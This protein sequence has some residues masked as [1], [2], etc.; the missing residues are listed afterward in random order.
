MLFAPTSVPPASPVGGRR[1]RTV[2]SVPESA[3]SGDMNWRNLMARFDQLAG[4]ETG[5]VRSELDLLGIYLMVICP[6]VESSQL[7]A[8]L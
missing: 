5:P 1:A 4:T 2:A 8:A 7:R 6:K 3:R